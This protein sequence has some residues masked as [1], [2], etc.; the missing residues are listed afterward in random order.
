MQTNNCERE[1]GRETQTKAH[2]INVKMFE[3]KIEMDNKIVGQQHRVYIEWYRGGYRGL[4]EAS[5]GDKKN[6]NNKRK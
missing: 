2:A 3:N 5:L 1:S 6:K 4:A